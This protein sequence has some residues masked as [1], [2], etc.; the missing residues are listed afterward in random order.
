MEI[1]GEIPSCQNSFIDNTTEGGY[2]QIRTIRADDN[3]TAANS[4]IIYSGTTTTVN[5]AIQD[6]CIFPN[7]ATTSLSISSAEEISTIEIFSATGQSLLQINVNNTNTTCDIKHL[8]SGLYFIV[9]SNSNGIIG[10][11]KFVKE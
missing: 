2:Y 4:N 8:T 11:K 5:S 6:F 10:I 3:N 1:I 7:P 9:A